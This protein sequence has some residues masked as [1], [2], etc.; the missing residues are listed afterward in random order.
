MYSPVY[1]LYSPEYDL[2]PREYDT[3]SSEYDLYPREFDIRSSEFIIPARQR[4]IGFRAGI[5]NPEI[6]K[7]AFHGSFA[8]EISSQFQPD[9]K[10]VDCRRLH[11]SH[12]GSGLGKRYR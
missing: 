9:F 8:L 7:P 5:E 4:D 2:Y 6:K 10:V 1:D 11:F 3:H 12:D